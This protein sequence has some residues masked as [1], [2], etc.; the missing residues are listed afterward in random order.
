MRRRKFST[1]LGGAATAS[2]LW[3][4]AARVQQKAKPVIGA[5]Y[6]GAPTLIPLPD[7]SRISRG[8]N[9]GGRIP[10]GKGSI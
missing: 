6:A 7:S 5:L 8:T 9:R 3:P 4:F 2:I 1:L 10:L